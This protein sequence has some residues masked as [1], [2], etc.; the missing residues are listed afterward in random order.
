M[1]DKCLL[2]LLSRFR[3]RAFFQTC[4]S[5]RRVYTFALAFRPRFPS[6]THTSSS[7]SSSSFSSSSTQSSPPSDLESV[8]HHVLIAH[9]SAPRGG[10]SA[11]SVTSPPYPTILVSAPPAAVTPS[12]PG[13]LGCSHSHPSSRL[14]SQGRA[15]IPPLFLHN[16][17]F[18]EGRPFSASTWPREKRAR[19]A[20]CLLG[21]HCV[22]SGCT[23]NRVSVPDVTGAGRGQRSGRFQ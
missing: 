13:V 9:S 8:S 23:S 16:L 20:F 14:P 7:S 6:Y 21:E 15:L 2:L 19:E 5:S 17:R 22:H 4:V 10:P 12:R 1:A 11:N 18:P 3:P